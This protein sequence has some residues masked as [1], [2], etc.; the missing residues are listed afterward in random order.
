M[1]LLEP[2]P[3]R[4]PGEA[5]EERLP[6]DDAVQPRVL[7]RHDRLRGE[8][9]GGLDLVGVE[10]RRRDHERP[11]VGCAGAE[12]EGDALAGRLG[13]ADPDELALAAEHEPAVGAGR[14]DRRLDDHLQELGRVV[15]RDERLAE[16]RGRVADA[17]RARSRARRA[18]ARAAPPCR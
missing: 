2:P 9:R 13:I 7:E 15:G 4:E 10:G 14:L 5:V 6:L 17:G 1:R 18:A 16:A 3:V 11:E 12:R 8:R